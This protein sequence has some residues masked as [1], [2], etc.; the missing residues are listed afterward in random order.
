MLEEQSL[1][2]SQYLHLVNETLA[3][4]PSERTFVVG[5]ISDFRIS[6]GKWINFELKDEEEDA[7][8]SCFATTFK[9]H[10]PLESGMKVKVFGRPKVYERFGKFSLNVEGVEL[11]GEGALAKAYA[12]LKKK[13]EK[14][15]LFD[16]ARKRM[17]P[18]FPRRIGLITST[19]AAAY[20]D[21]LRILNN[22]WG[23]VEVVHTPV[24]VQGQH[25]VKEIVAAFQQLQSL[26]PPQQPDVIILTR[27]GGSLED[28]HAFNDEQTA[29]AVFQS[30]IPVI[31]GVGHER[32]ES[33]C[34][35]VADLRA[36][37][38]SNAAEMVVPDR[39][40][41]LREIQ[42]STDRMG[43]QLQSEIEIRNRSI[44]HSLQVF[45]RYIDG[46]MQNLR[47]TVERFGH[48]FDRFRLSLV[49][50]R[51]YVERNAQIV[52]VQF[53]NKLSS[54]KQA[55]ASLVRLFNQF[56][57][58]GVLDRGYS[59]VRGPKGAVATVATLAAGDAIQV[60]FA[61]GDVSAT[62]NK[63]LPS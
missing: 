50:T 63:K 54:V 5:E 20:G 51:Q 57:V 1:S 33:L 10:V 28:L 7:K 59:I 24:H 37:T 32:D 41:V 22:R 34:D 15:G 56:N 60:Q 45:D 62:V 23:G 3:L 16:A 40:E 42:I 21:F 8:I 47:H 14:E 17:I 25:A 52:S 2:V 6:Q 38:P 30:T 55:T 27:G 61:K 9:I 43:D 46:Q 48:A 12:L 13:L 31:V 35:F 49:A 58:Q 36:S 11:V 26:Q 19:E 39:K 18:R 53:N 44:E 4:I 29:R